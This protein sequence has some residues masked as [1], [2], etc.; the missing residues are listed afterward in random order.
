MPHTVRTKDEAIDANLA[1]FLKLLPDV[2]EAHEGE[3]AL[4]RHEA[5]V[6]F[7]STP[8]DA[9]I[10]G[11]RQ[12]PDKLFSVQEISDASVQLGA[13]TYAVHSRTP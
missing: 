8:I 10:E 9:Q 4:L 12:F 1:A 5:I 13:Y 2:I 6:Q 7:Y 11:N 3:F